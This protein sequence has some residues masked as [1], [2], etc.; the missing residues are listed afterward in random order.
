MWHAIRILSRL[1]L[2]GA[3]VDNAKH[4]GNYDFLMMTGKW[5]ALCRT[6]RIDFG[7]LRFRRESALSALK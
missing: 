7:A 5:S 3:S 4:I 2:F 1:F 6:P